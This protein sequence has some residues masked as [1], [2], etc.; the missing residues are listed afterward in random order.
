MR[1]VLLLVLLAESL[2]AADPMTKFLLKLKEL[3]AT[4]EGLDSAFLRLK[5]HRSRLEANLG[6]QVC[7]M[8]Y[9]TSRVEFAATVSRTHKKRSEFIALLDKVKKNLDPE[10]AK[11]LRSF[12]GR[13]YSL[14]EKLEDEA[15]SDRELLAQA[16]V[17][18]SLRR[19]S[20]PGR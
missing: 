10:E 12:A 14:A 11:N 9:L 15:K 3:Q 4:E 2:W 7:Y 6:S 19:Q 13:I 8:S 5:A 18:F 17:H 20:L 1:I 16:V